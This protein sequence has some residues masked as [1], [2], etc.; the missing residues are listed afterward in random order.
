MIQLKRDLYLG[1]A[2]NK[3]AQPANRDINYPNLGSRRRCRLCID[4]TESKQDKDKLPKST[5]Q[6]QTCGCGLCEEHSVQIVCKLLLNW[7]RTGRKNAKELSKN[8]KIW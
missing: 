4:A 3:E 8:C 6:C 5:R 1:Q 2:T 7:H